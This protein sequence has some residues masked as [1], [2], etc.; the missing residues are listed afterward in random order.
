MKCEIQEFIDYLHNTR[1]TSKNTE[2]S[3]E[4]DLKKL[5]QYLTEEGIGT[6][7]QVTSTVLNSYV[8]YMERR[9]FA[10]SSIS[11]SIASIRA[12]FQFLCQKN[13]WKE[14]PAEKLKAPKI[15]KKLPD[16]L[17]IEEVDLLLRQ[18]KGNTAKGIRDKAMLEL[19]YATGIRVSELISL[20]IN[21]INLR[22]GYLTCSG[23]GRERVIPFG[24]TARQAL[25]NYLV[26]SRE[27][28]LGEGKSDFL[29]LNCSG[30]SMSRQGFWKVLK[31]Y[32]A[33]AG[34]QQDITPHTL[35]HSF[36]AHLV[37]N[38][39]DLKSV[40]EMMG[41]SDISTTQI[42]MNMNIHKIRDVY[43]KAHPRK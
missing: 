18:P 4:R 40:Q 25:E 20:K 17:T 22:L 41:H 43:M 21:N 10:A 38:G 33:S 2:V 19:L 11:R 12:F 5:E 6:G 35:R 9:N 7:E 28:L 31:G 36:A 8:L 3:Y 13:G 37:Q 26:K 14:N 16:I 34:I 30:K 15:E 29:F 24:T 39:A 1:G 42:Y 27:Q 23:G 32:A